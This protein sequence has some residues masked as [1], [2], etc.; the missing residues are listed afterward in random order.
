[1]VDTVNRDFVTFW[2]YAPLNL[3][4]VLRILRKTLY[5]LKSGE[6]STIDCRNDF[7]SPELALKINF[8][9]SRRILFLPLIL[10]HYHFA[11]IL[12]F[13]LNQAIWLKRCLIFLKIGLFT[14]WNWINTNLSSK[15]VFDGPWT[16]FKFLNARFFRKLDRPIYSSLKIKRN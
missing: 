1:M 10:R 12:A 13:R 5:R 11:K 15:S 9:H 14:N 7:C 3:K 4:N 2:S 6:H 16:F 8:K